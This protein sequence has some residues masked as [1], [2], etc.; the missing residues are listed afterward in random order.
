MVDLIL[1]LPAERTDE[2]EMGEADML[3][4]VKAAE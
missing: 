1:V 2:V 3:T 4:V